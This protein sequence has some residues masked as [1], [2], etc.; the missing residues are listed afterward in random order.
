MINFKLLVQHPIEHC[1]VSKF[2]FMTKISVPAT[3]RILA[4]FIFMSIIGFIAQEQRTY[5]TYVVHRY[6]TSN[7]CFTAFSSSFP[8]KSWT[9]ADLL[10]LDASK[11]PQNLA[12]D[13]LLAMSL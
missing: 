12:R 5:H 8:G 4:F 2:S 7:V 9:Q 10:V 6:E 11:F 1:C 13:M 3:Q